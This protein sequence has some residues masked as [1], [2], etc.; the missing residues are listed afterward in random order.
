[1]V[2]LLS[3]FPTE[4]PS[5]MKN[6][7]DQNSKYF[8]H[9]KWSALSVF[10]FILFSTKCDTAIGHKKTKTFFCGILALTVM[11]AFK[12]LIGGVLS[13]ETF[14]SVDGV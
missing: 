10:F 4:N 2:Y 6:T 7:Q 13:S 9:K 11:S 1:M 5:M 14:P 3:V 8:G 12:L